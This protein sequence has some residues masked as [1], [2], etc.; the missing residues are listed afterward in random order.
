MCGHVS[1]P[2]PTA[3]LCSGNSVGAKSRGSATCEGEV[4]HVRGY[5]EYKVC[6][7]CYALHRVHGWV[8]EVARHRVAKIH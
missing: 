3:D 4:Q 8:H 6:Y 7:A 1:S 2:G 5:L